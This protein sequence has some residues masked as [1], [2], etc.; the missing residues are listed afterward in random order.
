MDKRR[1]RTI[2][3]TLALLTILSF[4]WGVFPVQ[5]AL[6]IQSVQPNVVS[7]TTSVELVITGTDFEPGAVVIFENFGQLNTTFV[8]SGILRAFLPAGLNPGS[9]T[10]T[11]VNPDSTSASLANAVT[12]IAATEAAVSPAPTPEIETPQVSGKRPLV[13]IESYNSSVE[14]VSPNQQFDLAIKLK[15]IGDLPANNLIANFPPGDCVPRES[16]GVLALTELDPGE[17]KK[18]TQPL[19]AGYEIW[20]KVVATVVMQVSYTDPNGA[21]YTETFNITL[22]VTTGKV[23]PTVTPTP[24]PTSPP[25]P[26]PQLVIP[27]FST[28]VYPLQPGTI[29]ELEIEITNTGNAAAKR[30]SMILGGGSAGGQNPSGTPDVG[31]VA[32]GSGDFG[33]F[34]PVSASNVQF[35]GDLE[36][37][38]SIQ[39]RASLIVNASIN[40]GAYP[41]KISFAYVD[42]SGRSFVDDQAITMLV[43]SIPLVDVNFYRQPDPLFVGQQGQL[44]I[45]VVNLGRK[46]VILGN[47]K[48]SGE[49]AQF[50]NNTILVGALDVGGYF[51]LDAFVVPEQAGPLNI[52]VSIDYTDDFNQPQTITRTLTVDVQEMMEPFPIPEGEGAEVP[53]GGIPEPQPETFWQK[54]LRFIK[55]LFGLDSGQPTPSPGEMMPEEMPPSENPPIQPVP[56]RPKG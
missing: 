52:L 8:S 26:R 33:N 20:G 47:M 17:R 23:V 36:A 30:V 48:A 55:G 1:H 22:P 11:V 15:N 10:I 19:T 31:G 12:I 43:Y 35:L 37:G 14:S 50:S 16:G 3:V 40:P 49:G 46:Q 53:G 32:G 13:V 56:I 44:P 41:F 7:N 25:T 6:G 51:T 34:A 24:T 27:R 21:P 39:A 2:S 42:D 9:Y 54:V 29:F 4:F 5:A 45:Q 28:D 38:E 18:F